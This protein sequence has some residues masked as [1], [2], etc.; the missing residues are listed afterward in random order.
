MPTASR[1]VAF[2]IPI[3]LTLTTSLAA[4]PPRV[5]L[6]LTIKGHAKVIFNVAFSPD[7]KLL[8]TASKDHT[9]KLWDAATGKEVRTFKGHGS[10]VYS[11]AFSPDGKLLATASEDHAVKLWEV[12]SGKEVRSLTGHG[13]DVYHVAFSPDGRRLASCSQDRSVRIWDVASGKSLHTLSGHGDRIVTVSFSP[14]GRRVASACATGGGGSDPAGE[15]KIWDVESGESLFALPPGQGVV[16]IQFSPDGRWLAGSTLRQTV[17]VWEAATGQ[18]VLSLTG[19]S[20]DVYNVAFSPDGRRLASCSGKWN[21]DHS[22]EIKV[23]ELPT[24]KELIS[25]AGQHAGPIWS[26][27]FSPHGQLLATAS[28]KWNKDDQGEV[29]VWDLSSLPKPVIVRAVPSDRQ[30]EAL[31]SDLAGSDAP[32]AYQAIW[33]LSTSS[34]VALPFLYKNVK[35][36][37]DSL[38]QD[39]IDK[40][41]ADLDDNRFAVREKAATELE[42]LGRVVFPSLRKALDSPSAEVRRRAEEL[43]EKKGLGP[44]PLTPEEVRAIRVIAV[45]QLVGTAEAKPVLEKLA[46]EAP[47]TLVS[48]EAATALELL[49]RR[50]SH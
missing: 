48:K 5:D 47:G 11:L 25:L 21:L 24:G 40:L 26:L 45:A 43:L 29:K 8:G 15:V 46:K 49:N 38:S 10:D 20:Y 23:W 44:P 18:E 37:P 17:K 9:V 35:T 16:T 7:G 13:G 50:E 22:G 19:H 1:S 34:R 42:R 12:A 14:D 28:G 2:A 4:E 39:R 33:D 36:P 31:W 30:L 3:L 32:R 41:I 27:A 6:L